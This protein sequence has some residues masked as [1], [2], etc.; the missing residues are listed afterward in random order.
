MSCTDVTTYSFIVKQG[1]SCGP[2]LYLLY[3]AEVFDVIADCG[4]VGHSYADDTQTHI[5]VPAT[6]APV[7]MQRLAVCME[8]IEQWMGRNRRKL[9]QDKT[10]IIWIGTCQQLAKVIA[11]ELTLPSAVV[12]FSTAVSDVDFIVDA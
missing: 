11:I 4:L 6:D 1:S 3:S 8:R 2:L 12:R 9:N 10:Q 7:A 5:S